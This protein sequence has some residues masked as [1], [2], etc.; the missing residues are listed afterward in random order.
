[1]CEVFK[2]NK[3]GYGYKYTSID[4]LLA[5]IKAAMKKYNL[6]LV[7]SMTDLFSIEPY[8]YVKQRAT[9]TGDRYDETINE[10]FVKG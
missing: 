10:F 3:S 9:K 6:I 1:M 5:N 4:E 7:P 2:K 8:S